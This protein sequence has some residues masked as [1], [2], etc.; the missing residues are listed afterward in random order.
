MS[1][2]GRI[3][4]CLVL[5]DTDCGPIKY[6]DVPQEVGVGEKTSVIFQT[7][8]TVFVDLTINISILL[9]SSKKI[10]VLTC[11][12]VITPDVERPSGPGYIL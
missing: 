5:M 2:I 12:L 10:T 4:N 6:S 3:E 1:P 11:V 7:S 9:F 8:R